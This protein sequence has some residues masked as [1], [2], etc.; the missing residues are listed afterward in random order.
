MP[1]V[2]IVIVVALLV[3]LLV[4][5]IGPARSVAERR[6]A[7]RRAADADWR[8][9]AGDFVPLE[10]ELVAKR[11]FAPPPTGRFAAQAKAPGGHGVLDPEARSERRAT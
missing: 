6:A 3:G 5:A 7:E 2:P 10:W 9:G 8:S 11:R 4:A 1:I